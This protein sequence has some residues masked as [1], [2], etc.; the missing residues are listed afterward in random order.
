[1]IKT[2]IHIILFISGAVG[3]GFSFWY[4]FNQQ[5]YSR[6]LTDISYYAMKINHGLFFISLFFLFINFFLKRKYLIFFGII[7]ILLGLLYIT[8]MLSFE[9][10]NYLFLIPLTF[11]CLSGFFLL[12][13]EK[14]FR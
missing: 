8:L 12:G 11:Y 5:L 1:M 2:T 13:Y 4:L 14:K 7:L 9:N 3:A 6:E 10:T